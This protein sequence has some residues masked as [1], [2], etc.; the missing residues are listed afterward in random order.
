MYCAI[1][2]QKILANPK[3]LANLKKIKMIKI[4]KIKIKMIMIKIK[5]KKKKIKTQEN[6]LFLVSGVL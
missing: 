6:Q 4:K 3:N 5:I 1:S 2:K